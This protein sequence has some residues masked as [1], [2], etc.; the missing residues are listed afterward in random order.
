MVPT[1][2][3]RVLPPGL[4]RSRFRKIEEAAQDWSAYALGS[5]YFA[6]RG[7]TGELPSHD[8]RY[9]LEGFTRA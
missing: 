3:V 5:G 8:N 7:A 4:G 2:L 6:A 1:F 9:V